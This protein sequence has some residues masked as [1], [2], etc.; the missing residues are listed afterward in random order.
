M[1]L[2]P[3]D[4]DQLDH[5]GK[6]LQGEQ[7]EGDEDHG[8]DRIAREP[9]RIGRTFPGLPGK[10]D[11]VDRDPDSDDTERD[12]AD[13][14]ADEIDQ[15]LGLLTAVGEPEVDPHV[16]LVLEDLG[17]REQEDQRVEVPLRL[18]QGVGGQ[19]IAGGGADPA[20]HHV[21]EAHHDRGDDQPHRQAAAEVGYGLQGVD[22][23]PMM[24]GGAVGV[25]TPSLVCMFGGHRTGT[26]AVEVGSGR[27]INGIL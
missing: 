8:L 10:E 20:Q 27:G 16:H 17:E 21:G 1:L 25:G 9:A 22:D 12:Q 24:E 14:V 6:G 5:L 4:P 2:A 11:R 3:E 18:D 19:L 26:L 15:G 7:H 23:R 13:Q